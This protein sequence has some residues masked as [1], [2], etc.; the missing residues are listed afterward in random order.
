[1]K[2]TVLGPGCWG[3][4]LAWLLT[5]NF[6]EVCVWGREQDISDELRTQKRCSKPLEVQLTDKVE[7]TSDLKKA[8]DG[9]DIILLVVATSGI[10]SVCQQIA[11]I[12]L[13][14]NQILVNL[15]KGIEL[16]TLLRMSEV[17]EQELPEA[18]IAILSGPTLAKEVLMGMPTLASVASK[19]IAVAQ[20][21]QETCSVPN[22]FRLYTNSDVIGVELGGSLKNVIAIASGFADAMNLGDNLRGAL[23]TRGMAEMVRIS[24]ALGANPSTLYGLSGMGDLIAT[25]SSP[26]SRNFTVG[27]ML[28]KGKKIDDIL[29]ELGSVAEG[30]KTSKAV[31]DLAK[32]LNIEAPMANAIY[33]AVYTD[34]TPEQ[35]VEKLMNRRLKG[36]DS[37]NL[38]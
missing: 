24:L 31:C 18:N 33:E 28:G 30:V 29:A 23:L 36:E 38:K 13:N 4:T 5:D 26:M 17:M 8:L 34:I 3:L 19:D 22:R 20:R 14:K 9:A 7:I 6:D 10:R 15:S 32:K 27:S 25:C 37:Y 21:V 16:D 2:L 1:M 35:V 11:K 12:G